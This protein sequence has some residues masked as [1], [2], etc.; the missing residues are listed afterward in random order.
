MEGNLVEISQQSERPTRDTD[1]HPSIRARPNPAV[2]CRHIV[3]VKVRR[4]KVQHEGELL[5]EAAG[6]LVFTILYYIIV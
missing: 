2:C 3:I 1:Q 5:G 4:G 6:V